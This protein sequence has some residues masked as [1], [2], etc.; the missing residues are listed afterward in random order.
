MNTEAINKFKLLI[1]D[2]NYHQ[3]MNKKIEK[4][5]KLK[6]AKFLEEKQQ[7]EE[8]TFHSSYFL[9]PISEDLLNKSDDP[10]I[11][12]YSE[13]TTMNEAEKFYEVTKKALRFNF[14]QI[15]K[16]NN[17]QYVN[18]LTA[19]D[20][21]S[22]TKLQKIAADILFEK[23][24]DEPDLHKIFGTIAFSWKQQVDESSL[25]YKTLLGQC[26]CTFE[27]SE[28]ETEL[29]SLTEDKNSE[30]PLEI[31]FM[32]QKLRRILLG[33]SKLVAYFYK[34]TFFD[35]CKLMFFY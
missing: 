14:N 20:I 15:T 3:Q 18:F 35:E 22:D 26:K 6:A 32:G 7:K 25:F 34:T 12:R 28:V 13:Q 29:L 4:E 19:L 16:T 5:T 27:D 33:T 31:Q 17:E 21:S 24:V 10:W 11:S 23:A 1:S 2:I 8:I 9:P 30:L